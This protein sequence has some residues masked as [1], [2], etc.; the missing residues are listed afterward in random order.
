MI[1]YNLTAEYISLIII[2]IIIVSTIWNKEITTFK[3]K[4]FKFMY[5]GTLISIIATITS[6]LA[7]Q[8]YNAI[9]PWIN[10][11]LKTIYF[12]FAPISSFLGF[13]FTSTITNS[14]IIKNKYRSWLIGFIPYTIYIIIILTNC[15]HHC[16]FSISQQTGYLRGPLYQITY[17]ITIIY[18]ATIIGITIKNRKTS[19]RGIT[20]ALCLNMLIPT[21]IA[22]FQFFNS[23]ILL[24][25]LANLSCVLIVYLYTQSNRAVSDKL[26]TLLNRQTLTYYMTK[27]VQT[28]QPF[29]LYL[30]SLQNFKVVNERYDLNIGDKTL[31]NFSQLLIDTF[32]KQLIFRYSGDEFA[33]LTKRKD[34]QFEEKILGILKRTNEHFEINS[35][36]IKLDVICTRIDYPEFSSDVKT[37]ISTADYSISN[38]QNKSTEDNYLYDISI[39]NKMKRQT[40]IMD[41]LKDALETLDFELFYQP[42]YS[43]KDKTFSHAEALVRLAGEHKDTIMPEE[44]IT[45]AEKTGLIIKMTYCIFEQAC[46]DFRSLINT[47]GENLTLES[48]SINFP[49]KMFYQNDL[50]KNLLFILAKYNISPNQIKIEITERDL[51]TEEKKINKTINTLKDNGFIF[52]LDDF[53]IE[54]SNMNVFLSLPITYIK[55][56]RSIL[57]SSIQDQKRKT[58]FEILIN[59]IHAMDTH[60]VVEGVENKEQLDFIL[61]CGCEFIQGYYFSKPLTFSEFN[62]FL[63][64]NNKNLEI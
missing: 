23:T 51:I 15:F 42:I 29:S 59:A 8:H 19:H 9:S 61:N 5:Y 28:K 1:I 33:I 49:Y 38:H 46:K 50:L 32:R 18:I 7:S 31:I 40:F 30:F 53:G 64:D 6:T 37:L 58:F 48:I 20:L 22:A 17:I 25:G 56:D 47:Y 45:I 34:A 39:C 27:F 14:F 35:S 10:E 2:T 44:F 12:I 60:V 24:S 62:N 21:F 13:L 52:K 63:K 4:L 16:V 26:T 54:Y 11:T 3:Q 41:V 36:K 57:M 55:I 43:V